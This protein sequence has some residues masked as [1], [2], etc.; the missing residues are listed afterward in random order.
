[1]N[2]EDQRQVGNEEETST[3]RDLI[4]SATEDL[5]LDP[6]SET[7]EDAELDEL[8]GS[9][10][11]ADAGTEAGETQGTVPPTNTTGGVG[12][13]VVLE[14]V[15]EMLGP[16]F[17]RPIRQLQGEYTRG[18]Q[19]I[20]AERQKF[21][22]LSGRME[23]QLSR[24][25]NYEFVTPDDEAAQDEQDNLRAAITDDHR[26]LFRLML[27]ELGPEW[28][29]E[30]GYVKASD[31]EQQA[32]RNAAIDA[33]TSE[34][35]SA[36]DEGIERY[37][38]SFGQRIDGKFVLNEQA[39]EQMANTYARLVNNLPEG[40]QFPGTVLDVFE[41]T[42]DGEGASKRNSEN[43]RISGVLGATGVATGTSNGVGNLSWYKKGEDFGSTI[44]KAAALASREVNGRR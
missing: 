28:A 30:N 15:E 9:S 12:I 22:D 11:Q 39:K 36:I 27:S 31:L 6:F 1:M 21:E 43:A 10:S 44:R 40:V 24:L 20:A 13:D 7:V 18:R 3:F 25:D 2:P 38:D 5:D 4:E 32:Q 42:F 41:I 17:S 16:E 33:R 23:E 35:S 19:E 37:G 34:L 26:S 29:Q 14:R 8:L